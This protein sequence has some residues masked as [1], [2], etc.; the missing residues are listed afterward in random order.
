LTSERYSADVTLAEPGGVALKVETRTS[1]A[2]RALEMTL[3]ARDATAA[4]D[5]AAALAAAAWPS[6]DVAAAEAVLILLDKAAWSTEFCCE[7]METAF[8]TTDMAR[9]ATTA[10]LVAAADAAAAW[11]STDVTAAL[12][13]EMALDSAAWA[14]LF[15]CDKMETAF[16]TTESAKEP[17]TA[18]EVAAALAAA[19][20]ASADVAA[21]LAVLILL[22]SA[23]SVTESAESALDRALAA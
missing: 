20:C 5:V 1:R 7:R 10:T 13:A 6:A 16:D 9:D 11:V 22:E 17:T 23:A 14:T 8:E 12:V 21:A 2:E 19:A 15:A 3:M 18:T 4:T